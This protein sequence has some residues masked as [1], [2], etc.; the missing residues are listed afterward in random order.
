MNDESTWERKGKDGAL[1]EAEAA[2]EAVEV[3][4]RSRQRNE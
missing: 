3:A 4:R 1:A 2:A